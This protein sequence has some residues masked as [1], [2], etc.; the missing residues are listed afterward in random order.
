[1]Q[2]HARL[3]RTRNIEDQRVDA[4]RI[5]TN[6]IGFA[7]EIKLDEWNSDRNNASQREALVSDFCRAVKKK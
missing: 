3:K 1:M 2:S 7:L 5:V 6:D 4:V